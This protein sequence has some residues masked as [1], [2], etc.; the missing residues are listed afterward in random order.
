MQPTNIRL[1]VQHAVT[2]ALGFAVMGALI[3]LAAVELSIPMVTFLRNAFGLL[4]LLPWLLGQP[5]RNLR[6]QRLGLHF[7]RTAVGLVAM[8]SFFFAIAHIPLAQAM[9]LNYAAPLYVPVIAWMWLREK[10]HWGIWP[11][12]LLGLAGVA[13]IIGLGQGELAVDAPPWVGGIAVLAGVFAGWAFVT[14][15]KLSST[16][17]APRI[18]FWFSTFS[19]GLTAVP[20][21][22]HWQTPS[23]QAW[24]LMLGTG[25]F[26]TIAQISL[27]RSYTLIPAA[28][29]APLN[30]LVVVF[31]MALGWVFWDES[32]SAWALLG[33][34]LVIGSSVV[35]LRLKSRLPETA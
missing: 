12:I 35:A 26:A 4:F 15:R 10:P 17:P 31:A 19:V 21:L 30:Y 18:V 13:M 34:L 24:A 3:K 5:L 1:G 6:T 7:L 14:I 23:L 22:V 33:T 28:Q 27:T 9:L 20:A 29:V 25:L 32:P 16:E 2:A 8:Y 11:L